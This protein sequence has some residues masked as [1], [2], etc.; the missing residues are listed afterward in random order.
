MSVFFLSLIDLLSNW[1]IERK[2]RLV[3]SLPFF[4][5]ELCHEG[6]EEQLLLVNSSVSDSL[7]ITLLSLA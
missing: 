3:Y 4:H 1:H 2:E 6:L 7:T 5:C